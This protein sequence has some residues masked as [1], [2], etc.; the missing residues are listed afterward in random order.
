M[1][2]SKLNE[3]YPMT[4][5]WAFLPLLALGFLAGFFIPTEEFGAKV[6]LYSTSIG[7]ALIG[8]IATISILYRRIKRHMQCVEVQKNVVFFDQAKTMSWVELIQFL[9]EAWAV[10]LTNIL[11][12]RFYNNN[13]MHAF[14]PKDFKDPVF[15]HLSNPKNLKVA[16]KKVK[17][18]AGSNKC[19]LGLHPDNL[20][21]TKSLAYHEVAHVLMDRLNVPKGRHEELIE[22]MQIDSVYKMLQN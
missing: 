15:V 2:H 19:W 9:N 14:Y 1:R 10:H 7:F 12:S 11:E 8:V 17:G 22:A 16:G 5:F 4:P 20:D 21:V 3:I 6:V 13:L 18:L